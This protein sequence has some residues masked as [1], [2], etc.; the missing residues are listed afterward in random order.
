MAQESSLELKPLS[1]E[2]IFCFIE[3]IKP[4]DIFYAKHIATQASKNT[5]L[6]IRDVLEDYERHHESRMQ[7]GRFFRFVMSLR[8]SNVSRMTRETGKRIRPRQRYIDGASLAHH[9]VY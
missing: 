8:K 9:K 6:S 4:I 5:D 7:Q 3:A 2:A 1:Q